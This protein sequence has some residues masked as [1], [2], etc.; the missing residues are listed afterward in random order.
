VGLTQVDMA[1][2]VLGMQLLYGTLDRSL[3]STK[4]FFELK[5]MFIT[6][7]CCNW[8]DLTKE[9]AGFLVAALHF[10]RTSLG[11]QDFNDNDLILRAE[12]YA[13]GLAGSRN[14]H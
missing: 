11:L 8:F 10:S 2:V 14:G 12:A 1:M 9:Q 3:S 6:Y 7:S 5:E 4:R 13:D